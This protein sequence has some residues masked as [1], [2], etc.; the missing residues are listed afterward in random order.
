LSNVEQGYPV[1][2]VVVPVLD[3]VAGIECVEHASP[4]LI[5]AHQ[6]DNPVDNC[7]GTIKSRA[8]PLQILVPENRAIRAVERI[9]C[10]VSSNVYDIADNGDCVGS[11]EDNFVLPAQTP[12]VLLQCV[13]VPIA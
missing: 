3:T 4:R 6:V 5:D 2:I 8:A 9:E 12:V 10:L 1:G 7:W 13:E 11:R